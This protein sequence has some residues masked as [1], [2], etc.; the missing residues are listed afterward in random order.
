MF[1]RKKKQQLAR[2]ALETPVLEWARGA[3]LDLRALF[4]GTIILGATGAGKSSS[5]LR[6]ILREVLRLGAGGI[7][8]T[9]K[10][11]DTHDYIR[12]VREAGRERDLRVIAIEDRPFRFNF[13]KEEQRYT[14]DPV[15][16]AENITGLLTTLAEL[17]E[18]QSSSGGDGN[19]KFFRQ[20][21]DRLSRSAML[22]L[23]LSGEPI[24]MANLHRIVVSAPKTREQARSENFQNESFLY[25]C[26]KAADATAKNVSLHA[27]WEM[28]VTYFLEE[29]CT[30]SPRTRSVIEAMLTTLTEVLSR[31][32]ARDL[33]C[34]TSPNA[35]PSDTYDGAIYIVDVPVLQY[36]E[37]A[38]ILQTAMKYMFQRAHA[39][40]DVAKNSR[41]TVMVADEA[42]TLLVEA[43]N[44]FQAIARSTRTAV[45]YATQS[46]SGMLDAMGGPS[47]EPR[48][49]SLLSNL[50]NKVIHQSTDA[51][52]VQ[53]FQNL[54]GKSMRL[55]ISGNNQRQNV[56]WLGTLLGYE[57]ESSTAGFSEQMDFELQASDFNSLVT[58]GPPHFFAEALV[59]QGGRPFPNGRSW[60]R[61]AIP[62]KG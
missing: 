14:K 5:T 41:P 47:S 61:T 6:F 19:E 13:V 29:W 49:M 28:C 11:E 57:D 27:D 20:G 46:V 58:G 18:T 37:T 56:D 36:R 10:P 43:D 38:R 51:R 4:A 60:L 9:V 15:M 16:L 53:W 8:F 33:I 42:Q 31:G 62:Q 21:M 34:S 52:T 39:R 55:M 50:T 44:E 12:Y 35:S 22:V 3:V 1:F 7:F 2:W 54:V 25:H 17:G 30:L 32:L 26:L 48:V 24:T 23:I 40:R 45:I 59:Y